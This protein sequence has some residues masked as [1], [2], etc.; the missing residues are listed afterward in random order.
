MSLV[1]TDTIAELLSHDYATLSRMFGGI[2]V[3]LFIA[4]LV[5]R[6]LLR[7]SDEPRS[8]A[9]ERA[10]NAILVPLF[11]VFALVI[12]ARFIKLFLP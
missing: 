10:L 9:G 6:E 11:L 1:N 5:Q 8:W 3:A 4:L 12:A 2:A 7:A